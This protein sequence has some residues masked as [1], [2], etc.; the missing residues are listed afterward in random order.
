MKCINCGEEIEEGV[1]TCP[2]CGKAVSETA[3]PTE[4]ETVAPETSEEPTGSPILDGTPTPEVPP[5]EPAKKPKKEKDPAKSKKTRKIILI[6][7]IPV[8]IIVILVI[9]LFCIGIGIGKTA[10]AKLGVYYSATDSAAYDEIV[11]DSYW[12]YISDTYDLSKDE[13][14]ACVD[15]YL[16]EKT[17]ASSWNMTES[18]FGFGSTGTEDAKAITD[19]YNVSISSCVGGAVEV[20]TTTDDG[21]TT[22]TQE[23]WVVKA[24][25]KWCVTAAMEDIDEACSE[26]A[27]T[28]KYMLEYGDMVDTYWNSIV[29]IDAEAMATLVPDGLWTLLN[30]QY[31][32]TQAEAEELLNEYLTEIL[33]ANYED[34]TTMSVS[35]S[36]T[37][38]EAYEDEDLENINSGLDTYGLAGEE[39]VDV[40]MDLQITADGETAEDST[41][42]TVTVI[43]GQ[44]YVYDAMYYFAQACYVN[45]TATTTDTDTTDTDTATDT[46]E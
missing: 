4:P 26:Y 15:T 16:Q 43:D 3:A 1:T 20:Q 22:E 28:A 12:T 14:L 36:I 17:T 9:V 10:V 23:V 18:N 29:G 24:D 42:V 44:S 34:I 25:G 5:V 40:E 21:D 27:L 6:C 8:A 19:A 33:E 41:Y 35:S 7:C 2:S 30:E 31:G 46:A 45:A 13:A 37:G 11:P 39:A 32:V 38:A